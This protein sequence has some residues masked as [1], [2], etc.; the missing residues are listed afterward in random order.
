MSEH[1]HNH[2]H[3]HGDHAGHDH[4]EDEEIV[5]AFSDE[6]GNEKEMVLVQTFDVGEDVYALLLERN[7]PEADGFILRLEE[8]DG[9]TVLVNIEEEEE[10]AKVEAAY[11]ELVAAQ[12]EE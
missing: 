4:S 12:G 10:W 9:E 6:D 1:E 7:N 5:V 3:A 8:E 11:N 2:N